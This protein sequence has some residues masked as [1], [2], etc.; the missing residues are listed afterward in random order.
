MTHTLSF[1]EP[2]IRPTE[3]LAT[4]QWSLLLALASIV[5]YTLQRRLNLPK[6]IGYSLVGGIAGLVGWGTEAVWPLQG[7][8]LFV[9]EMGVAV[10]LFEC[11]GRITLRWFRHNPMVLVQSLA[12]SILSYAL[13]WLVLSQL[14]FSHSTA[15]GIAVICM[16]A[17]PV[18][19]GRVIADI[20]AAGSVTDR[21][22]V[23]A[24]LS[25]LYAL[26]LGSAKAVMLTRA[27]E[28]FMA[29]IVPTLVVLAVSVL[30]GLA[31]ALLMRLALRFMNPLSE[32]TSIL[33]LTLIAAS[34]PITTFLGGS[35]PLAGL[36]GGMLLKLLHPRPWAWP[37]Q[38]GT[39]AALLSM[40]VFVIVSS[41]A[42]QGDWSVSIAAVVAAVI[43]TRLVGKMLGVALGNIDSGTHWKQ[44]W[45]TACTLTPM[46]AVA[47]L[48]C[49]HMAQA[50][51]EAG[52]IIA[53]VALP[54]ILLMEL[55][56]AAL[57]MVALYRAGESDKPLAASRSKDNNS[58]EGD[59]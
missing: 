51:P 58:T 31:L 7:T 52:A 57:G 30:V 54:T 10:L 4:L 27:A 38:L 42:A 21:S 9:L 50:S 26:A 47:L 44:A 56:G 43:L 12:E 39:A 18:V 37:R 59:A 8:V 46:S 1:W 29:G 15:S 45:W 41:V 2:W 16:A 33:I 19:L 32:N 28:G 25:T 17:S 3:G 36:L 53:S 35:A 34:A 55:L 23:L 6:V 48:L 24:T 20:R 5:G 49:S 13:V 14:G 22:M 11:G 40:M